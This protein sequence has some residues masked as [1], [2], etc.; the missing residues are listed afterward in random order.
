MSTESLWKLTNNGA[1]IYKFYVKKSPPFITKRPW[2]ADKHPSWGVWQARSGVWLWKDHATEEAG[3]AIT[4]VRRMFNLDGA[5]ALTK[6]CGDL[7]LVGIPIPMDVVEG[8]SPDVAHKIREHVHITAKITK[9]TARHHKF[10][11]V[12]GVTE[13]YC[14]KFDCYAVKELAI[15]HR[16][17]NIGCYER[18][19][20]YYAR[21]I[22]KVKIYF[23]DREGVARFRNNIPNTYLWRSSYLENFDKLVIHKSMKDLIT[24]SQIYPHNIATQNESL[25]PFTEENV[26]FI[27]AHSKEPWLFYGSD[28]DGVKKS[29]NITKTFDWKYINTPANLLPDVNDI[30]SFVKEHGLKKLEEFCKQ[31]TL[32]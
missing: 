19:F 7:G 31:K 4:M 28:A 15:N 10:W 6:I 18:V 13:D 8:D 30:Y 5:E 9:F 27:N 1:D 14:K 12:V 25:S 29:T 26:A 21:D 11:N 3:D 2:A 32:I 17:V 20:V 24:F 22:D 23:P 16:K